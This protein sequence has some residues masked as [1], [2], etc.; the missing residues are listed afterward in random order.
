MYSE[1]HV[2]G[3]VCT[4]EPKLLFL[5]HKMNIMRIQIAP[6]YTVHIVTASSE[7]TLQ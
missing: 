6:Q 7:G 2:C 1:P 3:H 5:F 4:V